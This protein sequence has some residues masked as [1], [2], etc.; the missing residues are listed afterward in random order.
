MNK[1]RPTYGHDADSAMRVWIELARAFM[2]IRAR[3]T[4]FIES[5][6]LTVA[7]FG[8]LEALYHKGSL[9]VGG[10][11]SLILSTPGNMT[12]VIK[13]LKTKGLLTTE[14]SGQDRRVTVASIT[15]D[16]RRLISDIFPVHAHNMTGYFACMAEDDRAVLAELLKRLEKA[17]RQGEKNENEHTQI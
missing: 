14:Q 7:Q 12:V 2:R 1:E 5:N 13:N 16:G 15:E 10:L 9:T 17:N 3:E 8:V 11:T 4:A 6:G